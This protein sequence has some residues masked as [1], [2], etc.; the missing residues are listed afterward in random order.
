M[1]NIIEEKKVKI[2]LALDQAKGPAPVG[3]ISKKSD[4]E[5]PRELL[6]Q[7][8]EDGIV[9]CLPSNS[10]SPSNAPQ[11]ELT[12]KAKKLLQQLIATRLEQLVEARI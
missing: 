6:R 7:L 10:W 2:I 9:C 1:S 3:Y 12:V 11:F 4:I 5:N 8:E